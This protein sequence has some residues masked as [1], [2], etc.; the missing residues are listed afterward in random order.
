MFSIK[1]LSIIFVFLFLLFSIPTFY[2]VYKDTTKTNID[3][4]RK[5]S[6]KINFKD[7]PDCTN[8]DVIQ[9]L[10]K[11]D[12]GEP[13]NNLEFFITKHSFSKCLKELDAKT[14]LI[15]FQNNIIELDQKNQ[16]IIK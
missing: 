7:R 4:I 10:L 1:K 15:K 8:P 3:K 6:A 5:W 9:V 2:Y 14:T 13:I 12:I 16:S 11:I